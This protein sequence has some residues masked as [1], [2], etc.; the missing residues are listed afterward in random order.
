MNRKIKIIIV[1]I[2]VFGLGFTVGRFSTHTRQEPD[3]VIKDPPANPCI[4]QGSTDYDCIRYDGL[5]K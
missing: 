1:G 2:V 4:D 3:T 5:K